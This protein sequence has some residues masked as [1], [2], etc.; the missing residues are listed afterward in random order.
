MVNGQFEQLAI[1]IQL[2]RYK[3]SNITVYTYVLHF[4]LV[5]SKMTYGLMDV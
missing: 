2:T 4:D 5:R 3:I 1:F